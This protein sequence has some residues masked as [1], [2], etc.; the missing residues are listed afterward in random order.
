MVKIESSDLNDKFL[1]VNLCLGCKSPFATNFLDPLQLQ[2]IQL[3]GF[4][5]FFYHFGMIR[6]I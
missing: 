3:V 1:Q 4:N 2:Y 6:I 5:H